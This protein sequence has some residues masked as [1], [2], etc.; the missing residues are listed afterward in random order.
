MGLHF[1]C[2]T[3]SQH[4]S[5]E[6]YKRQKT[7]YSLLMEFPD[8]VLGC[9]IDF[10]KHNRYLPVGIVNKK[11]N[12]MFKPYEKNTCVISVFESEKMFESYYHDDI[13]YPNDIVEILAEK[14]K[15]MSIP[16]A[17]KN[18]FEW[19]PFCVEDAAC[20]G[21][22]E[23][24]TWLHGTDLFWLPE[25]AHHAAAECGNLE[26]M[27]F[28]VSSGIGFPDTRSELAAKKRGMEHVIKWIE[29][30]KKDPVFIMV[31]A[32]R[33]SEIPLIEELYYSG[34]RPHSR[35]IT[36]ACINGEMD[37][38][39]LLVESFDMYPCKEDVNIALSMYRYDIAYYINEK[40]GD[41]L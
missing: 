27:E 1:T 26:I 11:F 35:A 14:D 39:E 33:N 17:I 10:C 32:L 22:K 5:M 18:G 25:N 4:K 13:K 36:E 28:L 30:I 29:S 38:L 34:I 41:Y 31:E 16:I 8:D 21:S 40:F 37:V 23:F 2:I 15:Y 3:R 20:Y 24:F 19:F 6:T 9:V 12:S 7:P